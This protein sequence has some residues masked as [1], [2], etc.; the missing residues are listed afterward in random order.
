MIRHCVML[1]LRPDHDPAELAAV[2]HG[3]DQVAAR[4]PGCSA[5][6]HGRNRDFEAKSP[7]HPYGFTLDFTSEPDLQRYAADDAHRRLGARLVALC[8]GGA[9]GILVFDLEGPDPAG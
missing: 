2:M 8:V 5:F 1:R 7:D 4:L 9:D 3:L 6:V